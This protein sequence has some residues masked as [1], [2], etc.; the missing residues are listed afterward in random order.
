MR[1]SAQESPG[2]CFREFC[3][4]ERARAHHLNCPF[5]LARALTL[6]KIKWGDAKKKGSNE[7]KKF[8]LN[9][10]LNS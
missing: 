7:K 2:E 3:P 6:I 4:G 9:N 1:G 8:F 10:F 5:A